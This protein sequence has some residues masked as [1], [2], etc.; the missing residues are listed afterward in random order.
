MCQPTLG[1]HIYLLL[2]VFCASSHLQPRGPCSSTG[3]QRSQTAVP[4]WGR[5]S[6][7]GSCPPLQGTTHFAW[8]LPETPETARR[9]PSQPLQK[10]VR[11]R[12][13]GEFLVVDD[14]VVLGGHVVRNVMVHN[15][16]QQAIQKSQVHLC[17]WT[18]PSPKKGVFKPTTNQSKHVKATNW[19]FVCTQMYVVKT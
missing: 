4:W 14:N 17:R 9:R 10:K 16:P 1:S 8:N 18:Y 6:S 7:C 5:K 12:K 13:K 11:K 3:R 19:W 2:Q 15:E